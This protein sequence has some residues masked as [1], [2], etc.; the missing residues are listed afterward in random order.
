MKEK[1]LFSLFKIF[2]NF[3]KIIKTQKKIDF[4]NWLVNKY[5]NLKL[6]EKRK[7][8]IKANLNYVLPKLNKEEINDITVKS[9]KN[10]GMNAIQAINNYNNQTL[11]DL[12]IIVENEDIILNA[13][14]ENKKIIFVTAHFGNWELLTSLISIKYKKLLA[15]YKKLKHDTFNEYLLVSRQNSGLEMKEKHGGIKPLIKSLKNGEP[16]GLLID[17]GVSSDN[18][19]E[20]S[21]F[22]KKTYFIPSASQLSRMTGAV[23]IP[24]FIYTDDY[25]NYKLKVFEEIKCEK[26]EKKEK[27]IIECTQKQANI[28]EKAIKEKPEL[29]FWSHKRWR[30]TN[31]DLYNSTTSS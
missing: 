22:G 27:D 20:V 30:H 26:T 10:L 29:W 28:F 17:Q 23:I 18:G 12:T 1:L 5:L 14:K 31:S 15:I 11:K 19:I 2:S 21:H 9:L 16:I 7:K 8:V 6:S 4:I 3:I 25:I 13:L 24:I